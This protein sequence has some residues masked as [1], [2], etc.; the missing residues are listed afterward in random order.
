MGFRKVKQSAEEPKNRAPQ[1][2]LRNAVRLAYVCVGWCDE[3]DGY[4]GDEKF[5]RMLGALTLLGQCLDEVL[6]TSKPIKPLGER[7]A[8][9]QGA[10]IV[11]AAYDFEELLGKWRRRQDTVRMGPEVRRMSRHFKSSLQAFVFLARRA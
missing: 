11:A 9:A 2:N 5:N 3:L 10:H 8:F 4:T 7:M 6:A 1:S